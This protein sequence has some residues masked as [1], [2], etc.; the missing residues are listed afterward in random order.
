MSIKVELADLADAV[1]G[2]ASTCFYLSTNDDS[3][4]HPANVRVSYDGAIF[5]LSAGRRSCR[6]S[7]A[8][9]NVTLLWPAT[10]AEGMNLIV[11]GVA[12]VVSADDGHVTLAP[13]FAIWHV[14]PKA[15]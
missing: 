8:R 6:N 7:A 1:A 12:T 9:P 5:T 10:D 4:P 15:S 14:Q 11:D 2:L 3:T 13:S